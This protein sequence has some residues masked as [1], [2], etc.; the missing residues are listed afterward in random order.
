MPLYRYTDQEYTTIHRAYEARHGVVVPARTDQMASLMLEGLRG[1]P[2]TLEIAELLMRPQPP[3]GYDQVVQ[4][5]VTLHP[6][7]VNPTRLYGTD[8]VAM[9]RMRREIIRSSASLA[10][11][12]AAAATVNRRAASAFPAATAIQAPDRLP[13]AADLTFGIEIECYIPEDAARGIQVGRYH[14]G[15]QVEGLPTGWNAQQDGSVGYKAG[16]LGLELVSP[17]LKGQ[18]GINQVKLVADWLRD[19]GAKVYQNCGFHVHVGMGRWKTAANIN[20]LVML[21]KYWSPALYAITGT[22]SREN[23]HYCKVPDDARLRRIIAANE[24]AAK[25][26][27]D[28]ERYRLLNLQPINRPGGG[29]VEWRV[30]SGTVNKIKMLAY[31]QIALG[32][33]EAAC[34]N[35]AMT[36][37]KMAPTGRLA[38]ELANGRVL[39]MVR[40]LI[41]YVWRV[42]ARPGNSKARGLLDAES[43]PDCVKELTR[44]AK[45]YQSKKLES[46][47]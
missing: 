18:D 22:V 42:P 47:E 26:A 9:E 15:I 12:A 33:C 10:A 34:G 35:I 5:W 14:H 23:G 19:K 16:Y 28:G 39:S 25:A 37:L 41:R 38:N 43:L 31:I 17:K 27:T 21:A 44:L 30:F 45:A 13:D 20:K 4:E 11:E 24:L 36:S 8:A 3:E 29:T 1:Y 2:P 7:N 32:L 6:N 40:E 46:I